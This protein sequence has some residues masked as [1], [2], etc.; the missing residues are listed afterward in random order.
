ML[1]SQKDYMYS[2]MIAW[3]FLYTEYVR[4]SK[5]FCTQR[6]GNTLSPSSVTVTY[7]PSPMHQPHAD[8]DTLTPFVPMVNLP[9]M[10]P[11]CILEPGG[12][13]G[14]VYGVE[15]HNICIHT[16]LSTYI[17]TYIHTYIQAHY[18]SRVRCLLVWR[19]ES[20]GRMEDG[21]RLLYGVST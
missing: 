17:H 19:V 20:G 4:S 15:Y 16:Y 3:L 13:Y 10:A 7:C 9:A 1:Y 18:L 21:H 6:N 11:C 12:H 14:C 2:H 5:G 8:P